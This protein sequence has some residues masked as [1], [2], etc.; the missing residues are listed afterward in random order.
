V[1]LAIVAGGA[2]VFESIFNRVMLVV[3]E[4]AGEGV[5]VQVIEE[6]TQNRNAFDPVFV[7]EREWI[8]D[9]TD[10][11]FWMHLEHSCCCLPGSTLG[12]SLLIERGLG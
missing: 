12:I 1:N 10:N 7:C 2:L 4:A 5:R 9:G 3:T 11:G 6:Y 8:V